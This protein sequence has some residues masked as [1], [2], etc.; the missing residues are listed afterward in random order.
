MYGKKH[1]SE[2][3]EK[4][5]TMNIGINNPMYGKKH[6]NEV[7]E[8]LSK[9]AKERF[10]NKM[11][12]P[13]FNKHL[14]EETKEKISRANKN[15]K[16]T[17]ETKEKIKMSNK[18]RKRNPLTENSK[19]KISLTH[20]GI[21][22]AVRRCVGKYDSNGNLLETFPTIIMAAKSVG[23]VNGSQISACCRGKQQKSAGF[24]WKYLNN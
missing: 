21:N 15:H 2:F 5:S 8:I 9:K 18:T 6:S 23:L 24:I 3:K 20:S 22:S 4:L 11:N 14:N 19:L 10:S 12:H 17:E 1:T 7:I 16:L 13:N